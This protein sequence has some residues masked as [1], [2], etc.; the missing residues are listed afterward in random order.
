MCV[1]ED[2]QSCMVSSSQEP[3]LRPPVAEHIQGMRRVQML[4]LNDFHHFHGEAMCHSGKT[5]DSERDILKWSPNPDTD[6]VC[7]FGNVS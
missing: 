3:L 4:N 6:Q 5:L 1:V 2:G 7:C